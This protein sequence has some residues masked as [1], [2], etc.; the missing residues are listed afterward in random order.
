[1]GTTGLVA[2]LLGALAVLVAGVTWIGL[3]VLAQRAAA[4]RSDLRILV[5]LA[6]APRQPEAP[7]GVVAA[8]RALPGV[9]G[10]AYVGPDA[11]LERLRRYLETSGAELGRLPANPL[12]ARVE[13]LPAPNVTAEGMEQL[14]ARLGQVPGVI[15]VEAAV[16][17]LAPLERGARV[18]RRAGWTLAAILG[19][20][21]LLTMAAASRTA[22]RRAREESAVLEL[23]G[24]RRVTLWLPRAL[25][26][27]ALG[28]FAAGLGLGLLALAGR[29]PGGWLAV[30]VGETVG[31]AALPALPPRLLAVLLGLGLAAGLATAGG[32]PAP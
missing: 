4:W 6:E 18:A 32:R 30:A 11:A 1:M 2:L 29:A 26:G 27:L 7:T 14:L 23:V 19:T 8:I 24:A 31:A 9:A 12:P 13:V 20:A 17:W 28:G 10:G 15:A 3:E 22:T 16:D 21:A 5:I 25:G